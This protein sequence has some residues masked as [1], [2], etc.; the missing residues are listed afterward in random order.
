M[1]KIWLKIWL[2]VKE[3]GAKNIKLAKMVAK[4][5]KNFSANPEFHKYK[6]SFGS[7]IT[8]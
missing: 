2:K 4:E 1:A 8:N 3:N 7:K 5:K 6:I